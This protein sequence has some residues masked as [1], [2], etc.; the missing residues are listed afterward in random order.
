MAQTPK[1][2]I[3][4]LERIRADNPHVADAIQTLASYSNQNI[5]P[6]TGNKITPLNPLK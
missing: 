6:A 5:T 4:Q 3:P 1:V 2:Q